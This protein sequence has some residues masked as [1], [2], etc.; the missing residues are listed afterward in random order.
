MPL[1]LLS[2]LTGRTSGAKTG[3]KT[4]ARTSGRE[5]V[6]PLWHRMVE[7]AREKA[8]YAQLGVADT[9]A[10]RF[11]MVALVTALVMLR[12]DGDPALIEPSARLTELFVE[13]MDGQL[14][15]SGI[16][17]LV[18]GKHVGKLMG[19]LA[20]RIAA[21]KEALA[22]DEAGP[23]NGDALAAMLM[24]NVTR[25]ADSPDIPYALAPAHPLAAPM[26]DAVRQLHERIAGL[27][28][29]DLLAAR[30]ERP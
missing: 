18:V 11:D 12:M 16:G 8:W 2:R 5:Q 10:G 28:R 14:R 7:I 13:D 3:A 15:Q 4:G 27:S 19:V 22:Q 29:D 20:G 25:L 24:R 26:A 17:D 23:A 30:I 1:S 21:L 9:V 6:R